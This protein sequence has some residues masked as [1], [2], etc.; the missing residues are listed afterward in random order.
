MI[1]FLTLLIG[2]T[3]GTQAVEL[4][5]SEEVASVQL[6]LDGRSVAESD[7]PPWRFEVDLGGRLEPHELV[8]VAFDGDGVVLGRARQWVNL[9]RPP[10]EARLALLELVDGLPRAVRIT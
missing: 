4:A 10:S 6:R 8:A 2:L 3:V 7:S 5:V 9:P 1:E